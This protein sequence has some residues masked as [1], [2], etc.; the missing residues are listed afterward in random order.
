[1]NAQLLTGT[2]FKQ[3]LITGGSHHSDRKSTTYLIFN[4]SFT[5]DKRQTCGLL[6]VISALWVRQLNGR[7]H[8]S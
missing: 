4:I 8:S 2:F 6:Y 5:D 3:T 1:M 7:P